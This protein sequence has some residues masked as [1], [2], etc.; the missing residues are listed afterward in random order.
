MTYTALAAIICW[1]KDISNAHKP[2]KEEKK[3]IK[4]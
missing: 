2:D 4:I 1:S 3:V